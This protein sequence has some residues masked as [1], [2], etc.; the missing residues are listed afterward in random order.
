MTTININK[1]LEKFIVAE[2]SEISEI[3]DEW[4]PSCYVL[5]GYFAAQKDF[6]MELLKLHIENESL[7]NSLEAY[8]SGEKKTLRRRPHISSDDA[9]VSEEV[10][11]RI[12]GA[13]A[14]A[15]ELAL[16]F[17]PEELR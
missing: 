2:D 4:I 6:A 3:N 8:A 1:E 15:E 13:R 5:G 10:D 9:S 12:G 7:R 16:S 14:L 17:S 11:A